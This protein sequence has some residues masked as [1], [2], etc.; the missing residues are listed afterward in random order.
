MAPRVGTVI[1]LWLVVTL[2]VAAS[3]RAA[4]VKAH[5]L[6]IIPWAVK[7]GDDRYRSPRDFEQTVRWYRKLFA[8]TGRVRRYREVNLPGVKYVHFESLDPRTKWSGLNIYRIGARGEVRLYVLA[9]E[10]AERRAR[11]QRTGAGRP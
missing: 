2:A 4:E 11:R 9:R 10:P 8:R 5:G 7:V 3:A 1:P 6:P